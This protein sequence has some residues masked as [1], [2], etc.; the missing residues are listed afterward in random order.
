[1]ATRERAGLLAAALVAPACSVGNLSYHEVQRDLEALVRVEGSGDA[2]RLVYADRAEQAPWYARA[3]LL[4][5]FKPLLLG[6]FG[7]VSAAEFE[8]PS[9]TVR[10][11][12]TALPAKAGD[13]PLRGAA[14][15]QRLV[16]MAELDT[17]ALNRIV[18]LDGLQE[19]ALAH[20]IRP[21]AG[22]DREDA[23]PALPDDWERMLGDFSA[24][25]P[26]AR[27]APLAAADEARYREV[28][29]GLAARPLPNW[30]QRLALVVDLATALQQ[31]ASEGLR[32]A[33]AAA[34][35][36]ALAHSI[37]WTIVAAVQG[38]LER[39]V[40]V[41]L[42]AL[43]ILHRDAGPGGVALLLALMA[44]SPEQI[45]AGQPRFDPSDAMRL[46]LIHLCGQLDRER[47]SRPV[48]LPGRAVADLVAPVDYLAEIVLREDPFLS[49]VFLPAQEALARC[50]GRARL[51]LEDQVS[52]DAGRADNVEWVRTWYSEHRLSR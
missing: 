26:A 3:A 48:R 13:D 38:Q 33:T 30:P 49:P 46:R 35:Q 9:A 2:Q 28:L 29:A 52:P 34:L 15:A 22:L 20:G 24:L 39:W 43:E 11:L 7:D 40:D 41:R 42:R 36:G 45:T 25:R 51:G 14:T 32:P 47:A 10:D 16:R 1:M 8:N 4:L 37:R 12:V 19:L 50:L 23:Q 27:T 44:S 21:T 5:P 17:S 18:A 31:E 6:A